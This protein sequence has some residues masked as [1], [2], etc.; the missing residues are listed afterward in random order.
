MAA[1]GAMAPLLQ[2]PLN[3]DPSHVA[4]PLQGLALTEMP[5][6]AARSF[7]RSPCFRGGGN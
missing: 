5:V 2:S 6:C 1:K 7:T 4:S 3:K